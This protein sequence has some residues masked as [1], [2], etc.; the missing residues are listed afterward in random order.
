MYLSMPLPYHPPWTAPKR[1]LS[2][3]VPISYLLL[4]QYHP[5]TLS[6]YSSTLVPASNVIFCVGLRMYH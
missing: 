1:F 5:T 2:Y 4:L 6:R 3:S